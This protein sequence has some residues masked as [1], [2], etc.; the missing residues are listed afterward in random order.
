MRTGLMW[1]QDVGF[2]YLMPFSTRRMLLIGTA[3]PLNVSG[4][5]QQFG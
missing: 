5:N 3:I 2:A 1:K 4:E